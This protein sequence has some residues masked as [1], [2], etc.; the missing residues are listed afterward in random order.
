M[1]CHLFKLV[2]LVSAASISFL[3][4]AD[5]QTFPKPP[6]SLS[7]QQRGTDVTLV[8]LRWGPRPG[9]A[10]YRLQLATD[11]D[12]VDIVFDRVVSGNQ[13]QINN[14]PAGKYFW[15][16]AALTAKLGDFSSAGIIEINAELSIA[17]KQ[18]IKNARS[19]DRIDSSKL[20]ASGGGWQTA[21]GSV[22]R[23]A[24]ARL[25]TP[26]SL[27]LIAVNNEGI[28][29]ALNISDGV[30]LWTVRFLNQK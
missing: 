29:S 28:V 15:R 11:S 2:L 7:T 12:F 14:L 22:S 30:P 21:I 18:N 13:Y 5:A 24:L 19:N 8:T 4:R 23:M 17:A 1:H 25:R 26:T 20:V 16:V 3:L 6:A 10:R 9:V 27:E